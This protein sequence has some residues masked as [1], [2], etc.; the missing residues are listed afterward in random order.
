[1]LRNETWISLEM[2]IMK[3][4]RNIDGVFK[5]CWDKIVGRWRRPTPND[6]AHTTTRFQ[7]IIIAKEN[8]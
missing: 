3:R 6:V 7:E 1:M 8:C 4:D 5:K 2:H